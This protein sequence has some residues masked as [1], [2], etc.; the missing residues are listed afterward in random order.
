M[1]HYYLAK[2][3]YSN[4]I[5]IT[6][7]EITVSDIW[8]SIQLGWRDFMHQPS[9]Y[10]FAIILYPFIGIV[11]WL[12][13]SEVNTIQLVFPMMTGFA[14][15]G[16]FIAIFLYEISRRLENDLDTSW[17]KV[18]QVVH[19][20]AIREILILSIMLL[21]L[22]CVWMI[23]ANILF[24]SLYGSRYP[25]SLLIFLIEVILTPRGWVLIILGNGMGI[26]FAL[27]ALYTTVVAFPILIDARVSAIRSIQISMLAVR[28]NPIPLILWGFVV[29]LGLLMGV[30]CVMVGLII[31]FPVFGHATWHLYRKVVHI[32]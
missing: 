14:L 17:S 11:L 19:S 21:G 26:C 1:A 31:A 32:S 10:F 2:T 29:S 9:H 5:D 6:V 7:N 15:L 28:M 22:F 24:F 25:T 4:D 18:F 13:A 20:P 3:D 27:A 12:W 23:S 30:L 16:P 8:V